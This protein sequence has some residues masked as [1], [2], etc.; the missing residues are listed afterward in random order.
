MHV[1]QQRFS[2]SFE[3]PVYFVRGA[4]EAP[5]TALL[6]A[7][8]R[9]EPG[10][11]HRVA[12][13]LE[14][15]VAR[16]WPRLEDQIRACVARVPDVL[17]L[18]GVVKVPGGEACKND[19][20]LPMR[21][22]RQLD[23]WHL[24]RQSVLVVLGGGALQD[25]A[26]Y[27]AAIAH[28]GLRVVR[29]PTTV[30]SQNDGGVGVKNGINAFGKKNLVGT[31]APPY[32]V[33]DD[34][35]FLETLEPRDKT[36]GMAEAVK[37]ALLKDASFFAWL[38]GHADRLA[39]FER[40][41]L[42]DLVRRCAVLHL[43]HIAQGDPFELGS[44]RPLDFGHWAAHKIE[45]LS[46]Y[47][48]RHGEAVSIGLAL[49][50]LYSAKLGWLSREDAGHVHRLLSRLGLPIW[51]ETLALRDGSGTRRIFEGI[52]EFREHLGGELTLMMLEGIGSGRDVHD[53]DVASM[54]ECIDELEATVRARR[55]VGSA[56]PL[57]SPLSDDARAR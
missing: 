34:F 20:D 28:R 39:R 50:C 4:F 18:F 36:S 56:P 1:H 38:R 12:F 14:E 42:E 13:V 5:C 41:A 35:Q 45:S 15:R 26:G 52:Q 32:A 49:D 31:F 46:D 19:P 55:D 40:D 54:N 16:L 8:S 6:D 29:M 3:Y 33:I 23:A 43:E 37:V 9:R 44:S 2:V 27:A 24:D 53:V 48:L 57:R 21:L 11:R 47:R 7:V 10:R 22:V 30:L 51:D 17:E 25:M